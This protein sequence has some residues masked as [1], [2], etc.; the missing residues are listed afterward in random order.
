MSLENIVVGICMFGYLI[1][2]V[3]FLLKGNHPW[4][5]IWFSYGTANLG[6]IWAQNVK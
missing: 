2:G 3:S 6:L 4:A 1:V 5:L